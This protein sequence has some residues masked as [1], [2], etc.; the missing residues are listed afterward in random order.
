MANNDIP[1]LVAGPAG[2]RRLVEDIAVSKIREVGN[3]GMGMDDII[4]L[5]YGE[6]DQPTPE[7]ICQAAADSLARG[8]TF[9]TENFGITPLRE[10][11]ADYM[12][13]LYQ[14]PVE[15]ERIAVTASGM[16]ATNLMQQVL[17]DPGDNIIVT[18]PIWPNLI[19]A[20]RIMGGEPRFA[21]LRFGNQGWNLDLEALFAMV[22]GRTR[23]I[24][25]NSPS[26][27]TGWVMSHED[28]QTVLDFCRQRGIWLLS[29]EVYARMTYE[30][31]IAP[32]LIDLAE[33]EDRVVVVNSFSKSWCMTGWRLGWLTAPVSLMPTLEKMIEFHYSCPAHFSQVAGITAVRDG[34]EFVR[35]TVARYRQ[36]RDLVIDR[37]QQMPRIRVH[38]PAGAFYAFFAVDGMTDSLAMCKDVLHQTKVGLAPGAA[39]GSEGE[40]YIRLCF[41]STLE[42]LEVAM[43][44]LEKVFS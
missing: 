2:A 6:P 28:L 29:D 4:A 34:E 9:Y 36:A 16:S 26:N 10:A 31:P 41:A 1:S 38:R 35:E 11:I 3:A 24:L 30:V 32:S 14:R 13:G 44:R 37:L 43:D 18:A 22:D 5:W 27:P 12:T 15:V 20:V 23:A 7:F 40:G 21:W 42:R 17:T 33:P 8:E 39:F 25:I 19:E